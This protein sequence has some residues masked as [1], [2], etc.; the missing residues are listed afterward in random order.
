M[1]SCERSAAPGARGDRESV[2]A[3]LFVGDVLQMS[4]SDSSDDESSSSGDELGSSEL[5]SHLKKDTAAAPT[6]VTCRGEEARND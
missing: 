2:L 1:D 4:S 5:D 6:Q 3:R